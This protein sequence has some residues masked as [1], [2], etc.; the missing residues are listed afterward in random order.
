MSTAPQVEVVGARTVVTTL[1]QAARSMADMA[2]QPVGA[3]VQSRSR[4]AAPY[5]S[6]ALRA[7]LAVS[8]E[9]GTVQV[10]SGLPYAHVIHNGWAAHNIRANPFLIPVAEDTADIWGRYYQT[11]AARIASAEVR[12]A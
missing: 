8:I 11:E 4:A 3:L 9:P 7:S 5:V 2:P 6:G 12:G 10:G 1:G